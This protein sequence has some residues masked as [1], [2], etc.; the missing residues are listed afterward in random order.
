[1]T[2][3][4]QQLFDWID[5]NGPAAGMEPRFASIEIV[6][7]VAIVRL[8]VDHWSGKLAGTDAHMSDVF[9]LIKIRRRVEDLAED[10]PSAHVRWAFSTTGRV[11]FAHQDRWAIRVMGTARPTG[12]SNMSAANKEVVRRFTEELWGRGDL[13]VA[14]EVLAADLVEHNPLPGQGPA[15]EG[16]KAIVAAFRAAFPDLRVRADELLCEGDKVALRWTAE[17]TH[18]GELMGTS[19]TGR[20]VRLSGIE[21]LRLEDGLIVERWAEDNGLSVMRQLGVIPE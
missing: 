2:G 16:H 6:N 17:G 11:G 10:V 15:R 4:I 14:E 19:A 18:T 9:T 3:P 21:I 12:S 20:R 7:T 5:A 8:E 1:M 13:R